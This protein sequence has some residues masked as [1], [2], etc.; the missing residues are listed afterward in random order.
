VV[1]LELKP[2]FRTDPDQLSL[3][4]IS[5]SNGKLVPLSAVADIS[6]DIGPLSINHTGQ[7]ISVT[8]SF[9]LL[10]GYSLG[11]AVTEL[12]NLAANILPAGITLNYQGTAQAFQSSMAGLEYCL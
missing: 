1:I 7:A 5:S 9:N 8:L 4:Y 12:N 2:E 3:L 11:Q 6:T 10:T